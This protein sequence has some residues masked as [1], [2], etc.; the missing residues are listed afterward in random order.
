MRPRLDIVEK[1]KAVYT[2]E[3]AKN[4]V[5]NKLSSLD[6][7]DA[8]FLQKV[9]NVAVS[10]IVCQDYYWYRVYAAGLRYSYN[11]DT[12]ESE[13]YEVIDHYES[14]QLY[15]GKVVTKPVYKTKTRYYTVQHEVSNKFSGSIAGSYCSADFE[16]YKDKP[17]LKV[18]DADLATVKHLYDYDYNLWDYIKRNVAR[19]DAYNLKTYTSN[20]DLTFDCVFIPM[21]IFKVDGYTFRVNA[22]SGGLVEYDFKRNALYEEKA[23]ILKKSDKVRDV[24]WKV[25]LSLIMAYCMITILNAAS[26]F[27]DMSGFIT[28]SEKWVWM[29][30][31]IVVYAGYIL[32]YVL[33]IKKQDFSGIKESTFHNLVRNNSIAASFKQA[34][35]THKWGF[36]REFVFVA[37]FLGVLGVYLF[38]N[39]QFFDSINYNYSGVFTFNTPLWNAIFG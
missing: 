38:F 7:C 36:G 8:D 27:W 11:Y 25:V 17:Q 14:E 10:S 6:A 20:C 9:K 3:Q 19:S 26:L 24:I 34:N 29:G 32:L 35:K 2:A 12:E 28:P 15:S 21:Y 22:V 31:G 23:A 13:T 37:I 4:F 1:Y 5:I 30:I 33:V 18:T 16:Y 39:F